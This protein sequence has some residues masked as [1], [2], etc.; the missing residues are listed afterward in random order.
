MFWH[1]FSIFGGHYPNFYRFRTENT[2]QLTDL[3]C[4][5]SFDEIKC[6]VIN[7]F[8]LELRLSNIADPNLVWFI[9]FEIT[10]Q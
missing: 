9:H 3:A 1:C 10:I 6:N 4:K 5:N 2:I 8:Y 7:N